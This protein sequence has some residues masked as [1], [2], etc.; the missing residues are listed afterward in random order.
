MRIV[1]HLTE[2]MPKKK[3]YDIYFLGRIEK[4]MQVLFWERVR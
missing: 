1:I 2:E 4:D 3:Q